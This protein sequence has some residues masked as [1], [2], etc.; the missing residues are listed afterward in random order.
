[1]LTFILPPC[2]YTDEVHYNEK[3]IHCRDLKYSFLNKVCVDPTACFK[4]NFFMSMYKQHR[5]STK[6]LSLSNGYYSD[7]SVVIRIHGRVHAN[8]ITDARPDTKQ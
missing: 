4:E 8:D 2:L 7:T 3:K 6:I 5:S 1:M